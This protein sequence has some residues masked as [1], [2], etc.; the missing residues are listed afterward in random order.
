MLFF[1]SGITN[2]G[3]NKKIFKVAH[4]E[5]PPSWQTSATYRHPN[6]LCANIPCGNRSSQCQRP[7]WNE[8]SKRKR[9]K[10]DRTKG[11]R[12][13]SPRHRKGRSKCVEERMRRG[14][15]RDRRT[16]S[17]RRNTSSVHLFSFHESRTESRYDRY[18]PRFSPVKHAPEMKSFTCYILSTVLDNRARSRTKRTIEREHANRPFRFLLRKSNGFA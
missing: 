11:S 17:K 3:R 9:K 7:R 4:Y 1:R 16:P 13:L 8:A 12:D 14:W 18:Y 5:T 15:R 2:R 10:R 6:L